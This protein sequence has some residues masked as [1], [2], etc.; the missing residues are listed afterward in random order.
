MPY[1][2]HPEFCLPERDRTIWRYIDFTKL[3]SLLEKQAL[4][5]AR[6]DLLADP[7]EGAYPRWASMDVIEASPS[8]L[9]LSEAARQGMLRMRNIRKSLPTSVLVNSWHVGEQESAAMWKLYLK[10]DEGVAIRSTVDRFVHSFDGYANYIFIEILQ[11]YP[12]P[13]RPTRGAR[14]LSGRT[15]SSVCWRPRVAAR[16]ALDLS[17]PAASVASCCMGMTGQLPGFEE[18]SPYYG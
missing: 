13:E 15:S 8:S 5:F 4:F 9:G 11:I 3:V 2:E 1:T 17:R 10:S 16:N 18:Q 6:A 7:F 14:R 12:H